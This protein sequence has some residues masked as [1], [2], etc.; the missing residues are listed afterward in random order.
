MPAPVMSRFEQPP[1]AATPKPPTPPR[2][3]SITEPPTG[4]PLPKGDELPAPRES[5]APPKPAPP[6]ATFPDEV[7]M[8]LLEGGRTAFV[9]CF[10]K[11]IDRDPL[12]TSFKVKLHVELDGEGAITRV[13]SD[14]SDARLDV[15]L[16]KMTGLLKFPAAGKPVSVELP[17]FYRQ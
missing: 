13:T 6:L 4:L 11:A 5:L 1:G 17:L 10:R 8:R 7:V 12:E 3:D 2:R 15:C 16:V 9:H 14:A